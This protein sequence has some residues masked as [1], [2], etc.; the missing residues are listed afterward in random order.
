MSKKYD[1]KRGELITVN[2]ERG[3]INCINKEYFTLT[4]HEWKDDNKL[5]GIAQ[6]N[7]LIYRSYWDDIVYHER[8]KL[9]GNLYKSQEHRYEDVQ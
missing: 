9:E 3:R 5:H 4:T 7:V 2:G 1:F 6:V 8:E